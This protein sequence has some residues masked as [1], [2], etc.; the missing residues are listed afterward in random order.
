MGLSP[1][2]E[3]PSSGPACRCSYAEQKKDASS[4]GEAESDNEPP[5]KYGVL[6]DQ[7]ADR[8]G[9]DN[10]LALVKSFFSVPSEDERAAMWEADEEVN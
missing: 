8:P 4:D 7:A 5:C 1:C 2:P 3:L 10:S 6:G 9:L